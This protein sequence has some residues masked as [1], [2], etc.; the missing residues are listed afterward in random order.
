MIDVIRAKA[1][2]NQLL[3][4]IRLFVRT[5]GAT[6]SRE[7]IAAIAVTNLGKSPCNEVECFFPACNSHLLSHFFSKLK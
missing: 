7:R 1:R 5:F 6:E 4:E 3:K 2:A